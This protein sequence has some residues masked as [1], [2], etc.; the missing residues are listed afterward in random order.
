MNVK[1]VGPVLEATKTGWAVAEVIR[2][3]NP[4]VSIED[5]GAYLRVV[6][7]SPCEVS[8]ADIERQLGAPF[9]LPMDLEPLRPS[10][11]GFLSINSRTVRWSSERP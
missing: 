11:E 8:C 5:R 3:T 9:R 6:A 4:L 7:P 2:Q 1:R 10:F